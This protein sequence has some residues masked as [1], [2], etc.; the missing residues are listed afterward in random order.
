MFTLN[1]SLCLLSERTSP[2]NV[3][4]H[5]DTV[6]ETIKQSQISNEQKNAIQKTYDK[7]KTALEWAD[8]NAIKDAFAAWEQQ[9]KE[10]SIYPTIQNEIETLSKS[11]G[12]SVETNE[13]NT[14]LAENIQWAMTDA[15]W[16]VAKIPKEITDE[17]QEGIQEA[18]EDVANTV[19]KWGMKGML[20]SALGWTPAKLAESITERH[21]KGGF[22]GLGMIIDKF[23]IRIFGLDL[24]GY[25]DPEIAKKVG[26]KVREESTPE[27]E[28]ETPTTEKQEAKEIAKETAETKA[29]QLMMGFLIKRSTPRGYD[30]ALWAAWKA[31]K[32]GAIWVKEYENKKEIGTQAK[33]LIDLPQVYTKTYNELKWLDN[34][35]DPI[36]ALKIKSEE[37]NKDIQRQ[38]LKFLIKVLKVNE[39]FF[40]KI[41]FQKDPDWRNKQVG[42]FFID[43]YTYAGIG[44]VEK[45]NTALSNIEVTGDPEQVLENMRGIFYDVWEDWSVSG[46]IADKLKELEENEGFDTNTIN[47]IFVK[48]ST[49]DVESYRRHIANN[50]LSSAKAQEKMEELTKEWGFSKDIVNMISQIWFDHDEELQ[51]GEKI[52]ITDLVSLYVLTGGKTSLEDLT[53]WERLKVVPFLFKIAT[54]TNSVEVATETLT[55]SIKG[56]AE[57]KY[58]QEV[59]IILGKGISDATYI[60]VLK[61]LNLSDDVIEQIM[62]FMKENPALA[63]G[64]TLALFAMILFGAK[65]IRFLMKIG[66]ITWLAT[67]ITKITWVVLISK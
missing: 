66:F 61:F 56:A 16:D 46:I 11:L 9:V 30:E 40:E 34:E 53:P 18:T 35:I 23:I 15:M 38:W 58:I 6:H 19:K 59:G 12:L 43:F 44:T 1:T 57:N 13:V 32:D 14:D 45:I 39:P 64:I 7:L 47:E 67:V 48:N 5:V 54:G 52:D 63:S 26:V 20:A 29:R 62:K 25:L 22:G 3:K 51:S 55:A 17:I 65:Y 24:T 60:A 37:K 8:E 31:I 27:P 36:S 2:D 4:T 50:P 42:D 49:K 10:L 21:Q 41:A 33:E 28:K